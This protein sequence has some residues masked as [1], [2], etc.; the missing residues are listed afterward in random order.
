[1]RVSKAFIGAVA[2]AATV[3]L[4][5]AKLAGAETVLRFNNVLPPKHII[6]TGGWDVWAK[7]VAKATNNRVRIEFTTKPL[8]I[9]PRA[10]DIARDG[11]ADVGWGVQGYTPGRF[12]S[13]EIVQ[14]P[15]LSPTAEALSVAYWRVYKKYFEKAGEYKGVHVLGVHT[16]SPGDVFTASKPLTSMVDLRGLKIRIVN[17]ATARILRDF[18][19]S[20]V[21]EP[22]PKVSQLLSK[23]VIDG[24]FFTADA[25]SAFH[26]GGKIKHWLRFKN[27]LYNTSFF[28]VM[29]GK[30][31]A[32]LS[33]ADKK[34][35][36]SVSGEN[37]ARIMGRM[38]D[39]SQ[40]NGVKLMQKNGTKIAEP[41]G[42]EMSAL[43]TK[44]AVFEKQWI[45]KVKKRGID[46][47]A[48]LKMLRAEVAAYKMK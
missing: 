16:H 14:I 45:A 15:F 23:G 11:V 44:Y 24:T 48:A 39:I 43:K 40:E 20:P 31:W 4:S 2:L 17:R 32:S 21:R 18:A 10:F 36:E 46:G 26:L 47:A 41:S 29:N 19:G 12:V 33:A 3:T 42:A 9:L 25:I 27:G 28:L 22:A 6:R 30:K 7:Q 1:M 34:A 5:G 8:G 37:F 38:W 13:A 35:I